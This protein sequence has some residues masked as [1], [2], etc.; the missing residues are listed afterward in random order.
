MKLPRMR[1]TLRRRIYG[2]A[3][4]VTTMIVALAVVA[5]AQFER[6]GRES[7]RLSQDTDMYMIVTRALE[8]ATAIMSMPSQ[9]VA[10]GGQTLV[11][12]T[13]RHDDLV[14]E[15]ERLR[16]SVADSAL[17]EELAATLE[18]LTTAEASAKGVFE[19]VEGGRAAEAVVDAIITQ[20]LLSDIAA[21]LRRIGLDTTETLEQRLATMSERI[22]APQRILVTWSAL[23]VALSLVLGYFNVRIVKPIEEIIATLNR[24]QSGD[25][26]ARAEVRSNDEI[27][28]LA[29]ALNEM[30]RTIDERNVALENEKASVEREKASVEER[31]KLAVKDV[32]LAVKESVA[33]KEYLARSVR[34]MLE[35]I[36]LFEAGDLT[37]H[38]QAERTDEIGELFAGFNTAAGNLREMVSRIATASESTLA[39]A[40][41]IREYSQELSS[42]AMGTSADA[43]TAR[44][45]SQLTEQKVQ[46]VSTATGEMS[47][48]I[49]NISEKLQDA[50]RVSQ[51]AASQGRQSERLMEQLDRNSQDIGEIVRVIKTIASQTNLLALN[52]AIEAA[53]AGDAGKGFAVVADEVRRLAHQTALATKNITDK[54]LATQEGTAEAVTSI[55]HV[56]SML[57]E[58]DEVSSSIAAA[59]EEQAASTEQIAVN[60]NEVQRDSG[61]VDSSIQSVA[62]AAERTASGAQQALSA[63]EDLGGV[64][65]EMRALVG[66]FKV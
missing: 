33:E 28:Q 25:L 23:I 38:L 10:G 34:T 50:V 6:L 17:S 14:E 61:Q 29:A 19:M 1:L 4:G 11:Q 20:E 56:S 62:E 24:V 49:S 54:V 39:T 37:V 46:L 30:T 55:N 12:Y 31:V 16:E 63:S 21:S 15:V 32:E 57:A 18:A 51:E 43:R 66:A 42:I 7:S 45:A 9:A 35:Q 8:K 44:D 22:R 48:N 47:A 2:G 58:I 40:T 13:V 5:T 65:K 36:R 53:R 52:A 3:I 59:M 60:V 64:A 26:D 27:G 41:Q